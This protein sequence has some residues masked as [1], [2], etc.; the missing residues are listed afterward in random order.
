VS[1]LSAFISAFHF[2]RPAWLL[3]LPVVLLIWWWL[4]PRGEKK[5]NNAPNAVAP[6]LARALSVGE[7]QPRRWPRFRPIDGLA[8]L[9]SL[10]A[11]A[12]AG[13]TWTRLPDPLMARTAPLVVVMQVNQSMDQQ[14]VPPSRLERAKQKVYDL[15]ERRDDAPTALV[16]YA[17]SAHRVVPLT[18]D[19]NLL[20][21]YVEGLQSD[22]MPVDGNSAA[23]ALKLAEQMLRQQETP[24]GILFLSDG[25]D[26]GEVAAFNQRNRDN[27]LGFLVLLPGNTDIPGAPQVRDAR[28]IRV[29]P[30]SDDIDNFVRYFD[31]S[32]QQTLAKDENLQWNDRGW[33]LA[34]PAAL[35]MLLWFRRGWVLPTQSG[36]RR[37]AAA[38]TGA[39]LILITSV[40]GYTN[41]LSVPDALA[42]SPTSS[43]ASEPASAENAFL[44]RLF[45]PDQLG[46]WLLNRKEYARA[47]NAFTDPY[48]R[49]YSQYQAGHYEDAANTLASLDSP[50]AI[51]T[52]AMAQ[53]K[54][55]QYQ[56]AIAG[57]E[58]VLQM[59]ADFP[60]AEKN[61]QLAREI[62]AYM[63]KSRGDEEEKDEQTQSD[64][65]SYDK[66][67]Q[68]EVQAPDNPS[69]Q[70]E[71]NP[72]QWMSTLDTS[73]GEFMK[74]RFALEAADGAQQREAKERAPPQEGAQ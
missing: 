9:L 7:H 68:K 74:Q 4:R 49:A 12:T 47:A 1:A 44:T 69:S 14:D 41:Y 31:S 55:G 59:D 51:F 26:P 45:T 10:L 6:H 21:P 29:T 66:Q 42:Q 33:W 52:R 11:L 34:W 39:A 22:V 53:V 61:L 72:E 48:R 13:P 30:D 73:T 50:E 43:V 57:F 27:S 40:L 67:Q 15:L 18:N 60:G 28:V 54:S 23:S 36:L 46:Q 5:W 19:Q 32:F 65:D 2:L 37:K 38:H 56:D 3:L 25:L 16:A 64:E 17:G 70:T 8:T 62:F 20:R 63:Q 58:Q 35:L 24:G 71:V